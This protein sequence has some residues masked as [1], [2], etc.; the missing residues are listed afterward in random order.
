MGYIGTSLMAAVICTEPAV[1]ITR[2]EKKVRRGEIT[3]N[4][5]NMGSGSPGPFYKKLDFAGELGEMVLK[6]DD[7]VALRKTRFEIRTDD[8]GVERIFDK[9]NERSLAKIITGVSE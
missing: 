2:R 7:W 6:N 5:V 3:L 1:Y 4:A 8:D 9:T